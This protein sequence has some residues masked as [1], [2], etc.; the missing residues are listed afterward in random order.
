ME[1]DSGRSW[2]DLEESVSES[3]KNLEETAIRILMAFEKAVD[4]GLRRSEEKDI[5]NWRKRVLVM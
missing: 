2:K 4:K 5:G 3:L 1:L